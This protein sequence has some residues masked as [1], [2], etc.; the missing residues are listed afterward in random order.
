MSSTSEQQVPGFR[1]LVVEDDPFIRSYFTLVL[2]NE[3][4]QVD[5]AEDGETALRLVGA[6]PPDLILLDVLM[7]GISGFDVCQ[8]LKSDPA[9]AL[10]P[11]VLITGLGDQQSRVHGIKVGADDFLSKPVNNEELVAR[12]RTLRRLH[13]T[14]KALEQRLLAEEVAHKEEIR[15]AFSRYVSPR[16]AERIIGDLGNLETPFTRAQRCN[17]VALF[18]DLRG[19]TRL[20][21][22]TEVLRVVQ[23][24]NEFYA[25]LTEA[26]YQH[27]GTIFSMAGDNLLVGFNVP[28]PQEDAPMRAYRCA[29][30][31]LAKF[32]P[33]AAQ[34]H[35][36]ER[37]DTGL[38]IGIC[39]GEAIVGNVG[40]PHYMNYTIIGNPVNIAA[41]LVQ[42]ARANEV[43]LCS[44]VYD[45][46]APLVPGDQL[47]ERGEV[48][49]RGKS[50]AI[51]IYSTRS[52]EP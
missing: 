25:V 43:L 31:M 35:A 48:M 30:D 33:L 16:L 8:Q 44:Q 5:T 34:W 23:M 49:L 36:G 32:A 37:H 1:I 41:R 45:V 7:P 46:I 38:G 14:R 20:T 50:E 3:G 42:I 39:M 15:K 40:S 21:E 6:N 29:K 4:L 26:A 51:K 17:L 52:S 27:D 18:A 47:Q 10:I 12:I 9:T 28:L 24:L 19:F 2:G 13:E 11:I 22:R